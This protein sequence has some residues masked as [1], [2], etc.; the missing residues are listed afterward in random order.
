MLDLSNIK[1]WMRLRPRNAAT[2]VEDSL[3]AFG[4]ENSVSDGGARMRPGLSLPINRAGM[5]IALIAILSVAIVWIAV[6]NWSPFQVEA[7]SASLTIESVPAGA[8]VLSGGAWK[9]KTPLTLTVNPGEHTFELLHNGHRKPLRA[10]ARAGAAVVHHIEFESVAPE[11]ARTASLRITTEPSNLRVVVDGVT[12]GTSPLTVEDI[13]PGAHKVQVTGT[14]GTL[15]RQVDVA[16]GESASV[17]ITAMSAPAPPRA[18]GPAAGW[19][20]VASPVALQIIEGKDII[21]TSASPRILLPTGRHELTLTNTEI[22]F[23]E[24]RNIQI[25]AGESASVKVQLPNAPLNINA[26]PWAEVWVDG[27]RLGATPIGNHQVRLGPH[28]V[29]F[30]HPDFG[31]KRQTVT[32][33]LTKPARVSVDMRKSGS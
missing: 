11:A 14:S 17:I 24:K 20:T 21:G 28:E 9:G 31:E 30:R 26:V 2:R 25:T 1:K 18:A 23:T 16:A 22:G 19:L 7:A 6:R 12:K 3:D 10:V 13:A 27:V 8:D 5:L 15:E 4:S 32:V 29:V 33:T